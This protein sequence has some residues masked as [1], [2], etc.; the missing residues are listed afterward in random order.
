MTAGAGSVV[1]TGSDTVAVSSGNVAS[2]AAAS[3]LS[4][5]T[6]NLSGGNFVLQPSST[7][8]VAGGQ[9]SALSVGGVGTVIGNGAGGTSYMVVSGGT[10]QQTAALLYV[11]QHSIGVLT[12]TGNGVVALG[13]SP[14]AFT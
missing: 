4:T 2:F 5:G 13:A 6:L 11:G 3:T 14:L 8:T 1:L 10:F 7:F 12:I 9:V